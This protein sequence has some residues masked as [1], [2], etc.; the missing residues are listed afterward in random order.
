MQIALTGDVML[1]RMVGLLDNSS[2]LVYYINA[3][4]PYPVLY[5]DGKASFIGEDHI[6]R[7][8]GMPVNDSAYI[9]VETFQLKLGDILISASLFNLM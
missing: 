7:K 1:G 6:Y 5:R 3:E 2:G 8:L 9:C 4:H